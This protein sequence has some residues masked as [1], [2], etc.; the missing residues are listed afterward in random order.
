MS[1][2]P[3]YVAGAIALAA[4]S[5]P[6]HAAEL[7]RTS[8]GNFPISSTVT[9]PAGTDTV[10][11]SGMTPPVVDQNAKGSPAMFGGNT[12]AQTLGTLK[13]IEEVLK[14]QNLTM[15][16]VV[17]MHVYLVGD[18]A[19]EGKMDFAGMMAAYTQFFGTKEQPNKPARTTVQVAALGAPGMFV[20]IE[21]IAAKPK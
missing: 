11:L 2:T 10:Y 8:A 3:L 15:G 21:V 9:V 4:S 17:M 7:A 6:S 19:T 1:K 16:D 20:E 18:P 5:F 14:S 12:Q 13:R